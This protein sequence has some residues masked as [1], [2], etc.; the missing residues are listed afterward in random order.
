M[1]KITEKPQAH[2][3]NKKKQ[4]VEAAIKVFLEHGYAATTLASVA[5]KAGVIR[6]TIYSH[7][8]NK[9]ELFT[10]IIEEL[11]INRFTPNFEQKMMSA[12]PEEFV[13]M[14]RDIIKSRRADKEYLALLRTVIG[15]SERFPDL[16][17]LYAKTVFSRVIVIA[18]TFFSKHPKLP[19]KSPLSLATVIGGSMM[20]YVIQQELL[21]GKEI[22]PMDLDD[23]AATLAELIRCRQKFGK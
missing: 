5:A 12:T 21:Y 23:V 22:M 13:Y 2:P 1:P 14:L 18:E 7:F 6:A 11:T 15:E 8:K 4:I 10:A 9:E 16:A 20:S 3:R 19:V 17:R